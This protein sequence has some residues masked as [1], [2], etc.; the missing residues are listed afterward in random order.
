M[1]ATI[2]S[3]TIEATVDET[4]AELTSLKS[5]DGT[6][7]LWGADPAVWDRHSPILFPIV[8]RLR[9]GTYEYGGATY[10][11]PLHGFA[12][13]MKSSMTVRGRDAVSCRFES[14][15]KT[16]RCYPFD[17]SFDVSYRVEGSTLST[18][19]LVR[20]TGKGEMLFSIGAHPGFN[21]PLAGEGTMEDY[22]V[23]F[24]EA[25]TAERLEVTNGLFST[26]KIPFLK[27]SRSF[28]LSEKL[29]VEDAIVFEDLRSRAV[30]LR[31]GKSSR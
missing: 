4:G 26:A 2:R 13:D 30:T 7:Y 24:D 23:E 10:S 16:R 12:S 19:W 5:A 1:K 27:D 25:E 29:F 31:N 6:E 14:D 11:L 28:A 17:F 22:L 18:S 3:G 21:C 8:G 15:E 9:N 20:N